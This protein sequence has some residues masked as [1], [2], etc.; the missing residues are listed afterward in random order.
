MQVLF[1]GHWVCFLIIF[2]FHFD[3][4]AQLFEKLNGPYGGGGKVYEGRN[5][6]L[7]QILSGE[8]TD[9]VIFRALNE[10]WTWTRMPLPPTKSKN[11][12]ISV[13]YDG[14]L[15]CGNGK[16]LFVSSDNAESW[17]PINS[18]LSDE[19]ISIT[20]LPNGVLLVSDDVAA[21]QSTNGG[22]D[23]SLLAIPNID[24]FY[25]NKYTNQTYAIDY[26]EFFNFK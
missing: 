13:G 7:F 20:A 22:Q 15:Y 8:G 19:V 4:N 18:P 24:R 16:N 2:L 6:V 10:G 17:Q 9:H 26:N 23:W 25:Y 12:P 1:K 5:G 21:F 11:D 14:N 3:L